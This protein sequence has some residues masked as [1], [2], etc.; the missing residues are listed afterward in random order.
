MAMRRFFIFVVLGLTMM[1]C[2]CRVKKAV[3]ENS[4][5]AEPVVQ[6]HVIQ[7]DTLEYVDSTC[8]AI[9]KD[10]FIYR[11]DTLVKSVYMTSKGKKSIRCMCSSYESTKDSL[12]KSGYDLVGME[13]DYPGYYGFIL[14]DESFM[15]IGMSPEGT[16]LSLFQGWVSEEVY[17]LVADGDPHRLNMSMI[18]DLKTMQI[19]EYGFRIFANADIYDVIS[20]WEIKNILDGI[21]GFEICFKINPYSSDENLRYHSLSFGISFKGKVI[22]Q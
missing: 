3:S 12:R 2:Q 4:D 15:K 19:I 16:L 11:G 8:Y 13:L 22:I 17:Q 14:T 7:G 20:L 6:Y 9:S 18:I 5:V 1:C 21:R 10:R